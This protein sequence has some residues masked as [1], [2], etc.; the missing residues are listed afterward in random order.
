MN[1]DTSSTQFGFLGQCNTG[2][3][4]KE[5]SPKKKVGINPQK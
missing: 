1:R 5:G 3:E 4:L 2:A